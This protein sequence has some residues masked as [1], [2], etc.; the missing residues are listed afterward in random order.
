MEKRRS[1]EMGKTKQSHSQG[2]FGRVAPSNLR[3]VGA[4]RI[5]I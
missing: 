1:T 2:S 5:I 4:G 3:L